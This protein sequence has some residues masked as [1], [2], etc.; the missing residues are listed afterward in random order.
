MEVCSLECRY[1]TRAALR[2]VD[3]AVAPGTVHGLLGPRGAGKTTLLRVLA[4]ELAPDGG[5]LRVP[6]RVTLVPAGERGP[7]S[8]LEQRLPAATRRRVALARAIAGG[9]ELLLIDEPDAGVDAETVAATRSLALR[10]A[11]SGGAVVWATRRLDA[12][13]GV[14]AGV[15]VLADGRVRFNGRPEVLASRALAHQQTPLHHAA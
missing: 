14:A 9:P 4:G 5:R 8:P 1:G 15:T 12:L 10:H 3:L 13:L 6:E 2:G 11:A 7:L